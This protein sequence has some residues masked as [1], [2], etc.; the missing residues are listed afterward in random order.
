[1]SF[2]WVELV[3]QK[4]NTSTFTQV[5]YFSPLSTSA[6]SERN[7][8]TEN[9]EWVREMLIQPTGHVQTKITVI[10]LQTRPQFPEVSQLKTYYK[11]KCEL[12]AALPSTKQ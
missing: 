8:Q 1:M 2:K 10:T 4:K 9:W 6:F 5:Q 12:S 7:I 11:C 3:F